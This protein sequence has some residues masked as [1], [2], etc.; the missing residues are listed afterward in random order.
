MIRVGRKTQGGSG[1]GVSM[2]TGLPITQT[3]LKELANQLKKRCGSGGH[4]WNGLIEI[5]GGHRDLSV[6]ELT[7]LG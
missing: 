2:L 6:A 5:Q 3:A 4:V 7:R 1:K